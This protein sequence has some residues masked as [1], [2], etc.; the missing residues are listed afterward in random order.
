MTKRFERP[1]AALTLA[2]IRPGVRIWKVYGIWPM[3]TIS[4]VDV[5]SDPVRLADHPQYEG[6]EKQADL[7]VFDARY[8]DGFCKGDVTYAYAES[9]NLTPNNYNDNYVFGSAEFAQAAWNFF[10]SQYETNPAALADEMERLAII[11]MM[12][13]GDFRDDFD[14]HDDFQDDNEYDDRRMSDDFR[15]SDHD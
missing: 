4:A 6:F 5:V 2:D 10:K 15:Y 9:W 8:V 11:D 1:A 12:D 14:D 3:Q 7:M 13:D